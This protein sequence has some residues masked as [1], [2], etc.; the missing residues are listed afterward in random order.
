MTEKYIEK[1]STTFNIAILIKM[2][3][4]SLIDQPEKL[5]EFIADRL[6]PKDV[7]KKKFGEVFTPLKLVNEML[8]K[9]DESY[10]KD[11]NESIFENEKLTWYDPAVGMGNFPIVIYLRLMD[12][13]VNKIPNEKN[14]KRHILEKMLYMSE[15][16]KKNALICKQIFDIENKF[17]LNIYE[18]D[19]LKLD[20]QKVFNKNKFD[21]IVGNPPYNANGDK[22]SGNTI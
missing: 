14:R 3:I 20:I 8:D 19:S 6:K 5:L 7:E 11:N 21:I 15:L 1:N 2:T 16:N 9:L 17:N 22:A 12:G 18:G 13:L 4:K 10:Q